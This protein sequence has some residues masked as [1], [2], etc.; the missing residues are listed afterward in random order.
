MEVVLNNNTYKVDIVRKLT[1]RNTYIRVKKDSVIYVTTNTFVS[2]RNIEKLI[3]DNS[4]SII[5]MLE[6]NKRKEE[7][8]KEGGFYYLGNRYDIVYTNIDKVTFGNNKI[9]VKRDFDPEKWYRKTAEILFK[10]RLDYWYHKFSNKIPYPS[11]VIRKM[12][13]RWG[14]CNTRL[15][16]VTLNLELIKKDKSCLDYVIVH[17][18]SHFIYQDHS[19]NFWKIVEKNYPDY[20]KVRKMMKED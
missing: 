11:I 1:N 18:L 10:E 14:V 19:K 3:L 12:K 6:K 20:L 5:K 17:E 2:N 7:K 15:K 4:S 9:F 16:K 13:T 8:I